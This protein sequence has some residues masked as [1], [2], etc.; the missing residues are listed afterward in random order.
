MWTKSFTHEGVC[1]SRSLLGHYAWIMSAHVGH[2]VDY[3]DCQDWS[4]L[5]FKILLHFILL[6]FRKL[7]ITQKNRRL[8]IHVLCQGI[9]RSC[10]I[11]I[12]SN[13]ATFLLC[14]MLGC[15]N[16]HRMIIMHD[17]IISIDI[18]SHVVQLCNSN[19]ASV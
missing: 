7:S 8:F 18:K 13:V 15:L 10:A 4:E 17:M 5:L 2:V 1:N 19:H 16:R 12:T 9:L 3:V 6:V 14:W 11:M